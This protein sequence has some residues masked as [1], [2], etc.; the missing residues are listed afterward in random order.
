MICM[1]EDVDQQKVSEPQSAVPIATPV[2]NTK[3]DSPMKEEQ[4]MTNP[5][6][7]NVDVVDDTCESTMADGGAP[8]PKTPE[9]P[10]EDKQAAPVQSPQPATV[11]PPLAEQADAQQRK[12]MYNMCHDTKHII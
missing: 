10:K 3:L 4:C 1:S 11:N 8:K 2:R 9:L 12:A 5:E 7:P 6:K